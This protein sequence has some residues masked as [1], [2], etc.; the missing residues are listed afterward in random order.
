MTT[1]GVFFSF[2][3]VLMIIRLAYS[4]ACLKN[5]DVKLSISAVT[6]TEG[7]ELYLTEVITNEKWLPLPWLAVKF[8]VDRELEFADNTAA[9]VSDMY[10]RNDLFHILMH[11]KITRRLKFTCSRR[12]Y[13]AIRGL[14]ITGWDILMEKKHVR[15]FDCN[16]RLT[17]YPRTLDTIE[18][19]ELCVQVYGHLRAR[20][21][22]YPD[23]FSFRGI[24][25]YSP[26]DPL[27]SI[28]FKASARSADLMV[29][30]RDY[31][32]AR[33][34]VLLL[35]LERHIAWYNEAL[36]ERAVKIVASL[37]ERLTS[38]GVPLAFVTNGVSTV[39]GESTRM[40]EGRGLFHMHSILE[41]LAYVDISA[42]NI[43]PFDEI[44]N[45]IAME[46]NTEPEYWLISAYYDKDISN[47]FKNL[48]SCG[49]RTVWLM[50]IPK[51]S[52]E[53]FDDDIIFA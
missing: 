26:Q 17:V 39:S 29:N 45:E 10:Y 46:R 41:A 12:G 16:T 47:A 27:K 21:P 22:I 3:V 8:R 53:E 32:N 11:Q 34:V 7:D 52:E 6:A 18:M 5:V 40:G 42:A 28:N 2:V 4:R 20:F 24:R 13:Y 37:A 23:P 15:H 19:D 9:V 14:E 33:R 38:Q 35:D 25:D 51:P 1:L 48:T 43:R 44:I 50:P 31:E 30:I 49:S 36:E